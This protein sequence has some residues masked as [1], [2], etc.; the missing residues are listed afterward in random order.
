MLNKLRQSKDLLMKYTSLKIGISLILFSVFLVVVVPTVK[1]ESYGW[2]PQTDF[3]NQGPPTC[4]DPKPDKNPILFQPNHPALPQPKNKGEV[5]LQWFKIPGSTGY[6]VYYG[7]SPKNYI[8]TAR[9]LPDT[10]NFTV[11]YLGSR[12]YYFAVQAK[13]GCAASG[14]S[15]EWAAR[16]GGAGFASTT[17]LGFVPVQ[18]QTQAVAGVTD[19]NPP[20]ATVGEPEVQGTTIEPTQPETYQQPAQIDTYQPPPVAPIVPKPAPKLSLWQKILKFFGLVR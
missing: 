7:L 11:S 6:N 20:P 13:K 8:F 19:Y 12:T 3:S 4:T 1:A 10:N 18:R 2:S 15:N 17:A 14:L 16:P 9:D 5:R